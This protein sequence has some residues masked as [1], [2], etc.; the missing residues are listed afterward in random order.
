MASE[1]RMT[2][3]EDDEDSDD[4]IDYGGRDDSVDQSA[5]VSDFG[6]FDYQN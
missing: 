2:P 6:I 1:K 5:S 3:Q 4:T